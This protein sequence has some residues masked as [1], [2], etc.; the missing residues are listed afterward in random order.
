M[1]KT[2][3]FTATIALL[4]G[5]F[6]GFM[7]ANLRNSPTANAN[8]TR[9]IHVVEH[10]ITDTVQEF[11]PGTMSIGDILGFHN[12]VYN[13]ADT[14]QVGTDNGQCTRTVATGKTEWECFW[15]VILSGGQITVEGPYYDDGTDTTLTVTGGT[16]VY[17]GAEG[18][19]LL[20]ARGNPVGS[21]YDFIYTLVD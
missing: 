20:H 9:T 18:S 7:L 19:M 4:I 17:L 11:H 16:G 1:K 8:G 5:L 12:P 3:L 14:R 13:A 21:E 10:A 2:I 15:T 6:S